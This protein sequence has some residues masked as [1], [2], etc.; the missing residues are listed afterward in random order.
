MYGKLQ[1]Q[2][3]D[4]RFYV[5][6]RHVS[7]L[8]TP[9]TPTELLALQPLLRSNTLQLAGPTPSIPASCTT[10]LETAADYG[11]GPEQAVDASATLDT[12]SFP[13]QQQHQ[14]QQGAVSEL[15]V[16]AQGS[17]QYQGRADRAYS[18]QQQQHLQQQGSALHRVA[19]GLQSILGR[20]GAAAP[21]AVGHPSEAGSSSS[22]SSSERHRQQQQQWRQQQQNVPL[23]LVEEQGVA[24]PGQQPSLQQQQQQE[25]SRADEQQRVEL[26]VMGSSRPQAEGAMAEHW[27]QLGGRGP[28]AAAGLNSDSEGSEGYS[29]EEEEEEGPGSRADRQ[30]HAE[31]AGDGAGDAAGDNPLPPMIDAVLEH[32]LME[33]LR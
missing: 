10:A 27:R 19:A 12:F 6:I 22:S 18:A 28:A 2:R 20:R 15:V 4:M 9:L 13:N 32:G 5:A 17:L 21:P 26:G 1:K 31:A 16:R 11:V 23:W 7:A 29:E 24:L 25:S 14:D 3:E 33:R 8:G 30:G